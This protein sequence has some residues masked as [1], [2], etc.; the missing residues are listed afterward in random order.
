M[1]KARD[2]SQTRK[3]V[4]MFWGGILLACAVLCNPFLAPFFFVIFLIAVVRR[5]NTQ[6]IFFVTCGI[7]G[8]AVFYCMY[9]ALT[10]GVH[11]VVSFLPYVLKN[12]E[13]NAISEN[14]FETFLQAAR[15]AKYVA[16]PALLM[17]I[18]AVTD[19]ESASNR[20][21][22][23]IIYLSVQSILLTI[24]AVKT[25]SGING[26]ILFSLTV[27]AFPYWI[28]AWRIKKLTSAGEMYWL[29]IINAAAFSMAS[30][31]GLDA[32]TVGFCISGIG[33]IWLIRESIYSRDVSAPDKR[34]M[35][36]RHIFPLFHG[37]KV[38][39]MVISIVVLTPLLCQ[40]IIGIYR[41]APLWTLNTKLV[42][43]PAKGLYTTESHAKQYE[44][45]CDSLAELET[46]IPEGRILFCKNLPWAYL[47]TDYKYGAESPWRVY[48]DEI[49][50][51]YAA[52]R[53]NRADYICVLNEKVGGWEKSPFQNNPA[54]E[55]PNSFNYEEEFW[56]QVECCP[57]LT[58]SE[59]LRVYDVR[60]LMQGYLHEREA[61]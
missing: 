56:K 59:W 6:E 9:L 15:Y 13:Q 53:E 37:A 12:S 21:C 33:G 7:V 45:I 19:T 44:S 24:S 41:D 57:V 5:K 17:S 2:K 30:N 11:G 22:L 50:E 42:Q 38:F 20:K 23:H 8:L 3:K 28:E 43:G 40:R 49:L 58:H 61:K 31:T 47:V 35:L 10:T 51:Y 26:V 4:G 48:T 46:R 36:D 27:V 39:M 32:G 52:C 18:V 1:I 25:V 16:I 55:N 54:K 29:G 60:N 34:E 14:I